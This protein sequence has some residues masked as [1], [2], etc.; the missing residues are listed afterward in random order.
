MNIFQVARKGILLVKKYYQQEK[1]LVWTSII[2][3]LL[4]IGLTITYLIHGTND[5]PPEGKFSKAITFDL[6]LSI[7]AFST[8]FLLHL[9]SLATPY[10]RKI[11]VIPLIITIW[12]GY[13]VETLQNLRGIDPRFTHAHLPFVYLNFFTIAVAAML[14]ILI[15][16]FTVFVFRSKGENQLLLLSVKYS[17]IA[18]ILGGILS[19]V[20]MSVIQGHSVGAEGN[21]MVIHFVGFHAYQAIPIIGWLLSLSTINRNQAYRVIH[22]SG[23][24]WIIL[25]LMFFIQTAIG[26]S[27]FEFTIYI[28]IA[29]LALF[30]W[31]GG[32]LWSLQQTS[33]SAKSH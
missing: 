24:S 17:C 13:F 8:G 26:K 27:I 11:F 25:I 1:G 28:S 3:V 9:L 31:V 6:A 33:Q 19:G 20:W 10:R 29:G 5:I 18:G 4:T 22:V 23:V 16:M 7:F 14:T 2:G 32:F 12:V 21:I 30:V 15:I